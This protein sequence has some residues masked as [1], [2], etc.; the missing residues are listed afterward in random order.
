M[1]VAVAQARPLGLSLT[2]S[3]GIATALVNLDA[4]ALTEQ[5]DISLYRAKRAGRNR[6]DSVPVPA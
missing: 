6:V 1:R 2:C 4:K 3:F 5:A